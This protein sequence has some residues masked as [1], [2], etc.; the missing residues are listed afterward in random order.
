MLESSASGNRDMAIIIRPI[1]WHGRKSAIIRRLYRFRNIRLAEPVSANCGFGERANNGDGRTFAVGRIGMRIRLIGLL[2]IAPIL[3]AG[4]VSAAELSATGLWQQ[5]DEVSGK[6]EGW[7]LIA[8][9][10]GAY[11]GAIAK[12]FMEPGA[13]PNPICT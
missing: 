4:A 2:A 1:S 9:H 7:F 5:F 8:E 6:S 3:W 10:G 13:N 12:M 11:E